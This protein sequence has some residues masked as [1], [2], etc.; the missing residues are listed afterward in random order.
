VRIEKEKTTIIEGAG[1]KSRI[2]ARIQQLRNQ[3]KETTS[4]YDREKLEERLAK[5]QGGVAMIKVGAPTET[6]LKEKKALAEN[7]VHAAKAAREEGILAGGGVAYLRTIP[8]L[9]KLEAATTDEYEKFGIRIVAQALKAP[10]KQIAHNSGWD[11]SMVVS[12]TQNKPKEIGFDAVSGKFVNLL[13]NGIID[14]TKVLRL[15]LQNATSIA[16]LMLTTRT[17]L[18]DLKEKKKAVAGT[19]R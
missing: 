8:L 10:L 14:S 12:E 17:L 13:E 19:L 7:A 18:T 2:K 1:D 11:G 9:E 3:I 4:D 15:A 6:E 5:L 16:G